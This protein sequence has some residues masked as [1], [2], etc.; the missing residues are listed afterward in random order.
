MT[1]DLFPGTWQLVEWAWLKDDGS[2]GGHPFG[3]DALGQ[4]MYDTP[5]ENCADGIGHMSGFLARASWAGS[6][7]ELSDYGR[8]FFAYGGTWRLEGERIFHHVLFASDP[9]WIGDDQ[10]RYP[11]FE[12]GLLHLEMRPGKGGGNADRVHRLTWRRAR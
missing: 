9:S 10:I 4:I 12:D 3:A 5:D 1:P 7:P 2:V 6:E 11:T 8:R